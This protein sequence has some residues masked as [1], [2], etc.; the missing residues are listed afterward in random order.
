MSDRQGERPTW[1]PAQRAAI[2]TRD[3]TLLVSAAAGSGKT[4]TLTE[5]VIRLLTDP[6]NPR[7]VSRLV[8][9][10]FTVAAANDL[11]AKL[12][13]ALN[14]AI[15]ERPG[16][17]RLPEQLLLLPEADIGTIDSFC[18]RIV[19][20]FAD[21][22]SISPSY[23]VCDPAEEKHLLRSV[24][25]PFIDRLFAGEEPTVATSDEFCDFVSHLL[26]TRNQEDL[27]EII[28]SVL[29]QVD[30]V[31][32]G[33]EKLAVVAGYINEVCDRPPE[34]TVFG[35]ALM[36][37]LA[38]YAADMA[39][40][41]DEALVDLS[42][43]TDA[44]REKLGPALTRA[45]SAMHELSSPD[46]TYDAARAAVNE[47]SD[48]KT[49]PLKVTFSGKFTK[50]AEPEFLARVKTLLKRIRDDLKEIFAPLFCASSSDWQTLA[51]MHA[52]V[53]LVLYRLIRRFSELVAEE[54][55]RRNVASFADV[56]RAALRVLVSPDGTKTDVAEQI[57]SR[58]DAVFVDEYQDVNQIQHAVFEAI[59]RERNRFLVGDVKQSIYMF[60]RAEPSIFISL[61]R[62]YPPLERAGDG[63]NATVF[64]SDNFRCDK[65]VIDFANGVFD[66]L[67]GAT[68]DAIGYVPD[69]RLRFSKL[70]DACS[71]EPALPVVRMFRQAAVADGEDA[72][73]DDEE[74]A[75]V[76]DEIVR[77]TKTGRRANGEPIK[78][79]DIAILLRAA[80][81]KTTA[82]RAAL[83]RR[84]IPAS[85]ETNENF[86]DAPEIRLALCL[87]NAVDNP[88]RDVPLV[89]LLRSP[90]YDVAPDV[91]VAIRREAS[92][93]DE[94]FYDALT[95]YC[96]NHPEFAV[97]ARFLEQLAAFRR[98]AE[99]MPVDRLILKLFTETGLLPIGGAANRAGRENL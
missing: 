65:P 31:P 1:S 74:C 99:R 77:L 40:L 47:I 87:L 18:R 16:D 78:P 21:R 41:A 25:T 24:L 10:T 13:A 72:A 83:A 8:I 43:E 73:P 58:Y 27:S 17:R 5:R 79:E 54:K 71:K 61:K 28:L 46:E 53:S 12:T 37:R 95:E 2:E 22:A 92:L 94:P 38:D 57:A 26:E 36:R 97:G 89:G 42:G 51:K 3:K 48:N 63:P 23:R 49:S 9:V 93:S 59:S 29:E 20:E 15:R 90:L 60:R 82:F 76:A 98:A 86:F 85:V 34:E 68:G 81:G 11:R 70:P 45:A 50:E 62:D 6:E 44:V 66:A 56:E 91:L 80:E 30:N 19:T 55:R 84:G 39:K 7:D 4:T 14:D 52:P 35:R 32:E 88:R 33:A 69:D 67:F 96:A 75:W 64:L